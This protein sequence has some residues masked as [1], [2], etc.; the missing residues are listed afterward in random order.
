MD[1]RPYSPSTARL[2][3]AALAL[4][5]QPFIITDDLQTGVAYSWLYSDDPR[6][7]RFHKFVFR[8]DRVAA[9]V[10][11]RAVDANRRL[12]AMYD[13]FVAEIARRFPGGSLLD[14]GCNN[15]Y[16]PVRAEQLGMRGCA[17]MDRRPQHWA[18]IKL[19]NGITGT[20]VKFMNRAYAPEARTARVDKRYDVVVAS[21][22]MC[23]LPDPLNFLAFL[24]SVAKEAIFF[25]GQMLDTDDYLIAYNEPNRFTFTTSTFPYGFDDNTRLS[26]GLFRKSLELLG[27]GEIVEL[28]HRGTWLP[29]EWYAPHRA[30]LCMRG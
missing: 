23:H 17:G 7:D 6:D 30:W 19:L 18:S 12:A 15:G 28:P 2:H 5:Y 29:A 24:G 21:A 13:D 1:L 10:W 3:A 14:V 20:S 26:R 8:R 27:F 16:Y 4:N 11:D 22:V 25:W 9:D